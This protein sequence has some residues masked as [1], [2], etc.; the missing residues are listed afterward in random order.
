MN[1]D[2]RGHAIS[3]DS[4][5]AANL[6]SKTIEAFAMRQAKTGDYLKE[7]VEA[8][9]NCAFSQTVMGL[10]LHGARTEAFQ[11]NVNEALASA[12]KYSAN[13]S[14]REQLYVDALEL[15]NA[16]SLEAA[17]GC[18]ES[19]LSEYPTDLLALVFLQSELFWLGD[20]VRSKRVS[21]Q[22]EKHWN[23]D[24]PGY[25]AFLAI[26]A[27]DLEESN[28]FE[29][30]ENTAKEALALNPGDVWGAHAL[31]HVML[32]QNRIDEGIVFM[33]ERE[34]LWQSANQM[35][36]HLAW[37]QCL[38]LAERKQHDA[39]LNIYD[40]RIRNRDHELCKSMPDLYIDLQNGSSLLWRLEQ[41]GV[42][43]GNRWQELAEV[44]TPRIDDMRNPFTSAHFALVLAANE[45]YND[46]DRLIKSMEAFAAD[47]K[48]DLAIRYEK[49]AIPAAKAAIAHRKGEH[50]AVLEAL[51][52]A[53][54][55]LFHMGGSHAQQ[56]IYFQLLADSTAQLGDKAGYAQLMADIEKIGF[57]E[58]L[59][60]AGYSLA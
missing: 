45:Q 21:D 10:M 33:E 44:C 20:M 30:A 34:S 43:V 5:T 28:A 39:M 32:M 4:A 36:Y 25:P 59:R 13:I 14:A 18:Y 47:A 16:G 1:T 38:F 53:Q 42:N 3:T 7:A 11:E 37:H 52:P 26:R 35:Q 22:L 6:L 31:A 48:H 49:A 17:V 55:E 2:A 27:F 41:A 19:I 12:I 8:D 15:S 29:Q 23:A 40:T 54:N 60:R 9:P 24:V 51:K 56:D 46:C 50:T 57:V 58:P